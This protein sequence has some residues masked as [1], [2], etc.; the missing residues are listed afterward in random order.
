MPVTFRPAAHVANPLTT[1]K[2]TPG[3]LL[4]AVSVDI[5]LEVKEVLQSSFGAA[6]TTHA[7]IIPRSNGFVDTVV[8]AY[9]RHHALVIR[10]DDVWIAILTYVVRSTRCT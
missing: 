9:S 4:E 7:T 3:S 6:T 1:A 5:S 10:P 2:Y 8:E